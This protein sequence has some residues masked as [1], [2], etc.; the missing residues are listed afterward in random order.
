MLAFA[1]IK[2]L[3]KNLEDLVKSLATNPMPHQHHFSTA[4]VKSKFVVGNAWNADDYKLK[5]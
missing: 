5:R 3:H 4:P 2:Y 1:I